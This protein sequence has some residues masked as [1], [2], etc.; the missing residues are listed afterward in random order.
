MEPIT[1]L[2]TPPITCKHFVIVREGNPANPQASGEPGVQDQG[3]PPSGPGGG[4]WLS[5]FFDRI[6]PTDRIIR[7]RHF[8]PR[9][10]HSPMQRLDG[11]VD[12]QDQ[13]IDRAWTPAQAY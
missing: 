11:T 3:P 4:L 13:G 8:P 7:R 9:N 10:G 1:T 2:H 6:N 12:M 5:L